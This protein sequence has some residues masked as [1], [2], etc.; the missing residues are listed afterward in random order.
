MATLA[1]I[2]PDVIIKLQT[3]TFFSHFADYDDGILDEAFDNAT[4]EI[5]VGLRDC[6]LNL[7]PESDVIYYHAC[8]TAHYLLGF[9]IIED[10]D[11]PGEY[12]LKPGR[13]VPS[14]FRTV[15]TKS[16]DGLTITY[17]SERLGIGI[18]SPFEQWLSTTSFGFR[19]IQMGKDCALRKG[20]V[21]VC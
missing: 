4:A 21:F 9:T 15:G 2:K 19:C 14:L 17:E 13:D 11:N 7:D 10:P 20:R 3:D 16:A 8:L 6:L 1:E 5:R 12:I 18:N